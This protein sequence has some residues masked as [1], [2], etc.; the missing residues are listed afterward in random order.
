MLR[1]T[2]GAD[3]PTIAIGT[4]LLSL[5]GRLQD[6]GPVALIIEDAPWAGSPSCQVLGFL[7]RRLYADRVL[8]VITARTAGGATPWDTPTTP[9]AA[10]R[11]VTALD[12]LPGWAWLRGSQHERVKLSGLSVPDVIELGANSG[13]SLGHPAAGR[14]QHLD[15]G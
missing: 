3:V 15:R 4:E 10:H 1:G 6:R 12:Q 5:L 14:L 7:S 13:V 11:G 2:H 8:T 9:D